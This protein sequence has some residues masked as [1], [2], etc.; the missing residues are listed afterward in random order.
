MVST[1]G[2][3][4]VEREPDTVELECVLE[5]TIDWIVRIELVGD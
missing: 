5:L 2:M 3:K 4:V 1:G